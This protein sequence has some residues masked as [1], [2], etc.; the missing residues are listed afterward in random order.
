[1]HHLSTHHGLGSIRWRSL[2][3][4]ACLPWPLNRN[5]HVPDCVDHRPT[6]QQWYTL[7][8]LYRWSEHRRIPS[9]TT[10]FLTLP[11][12]ELDK[13]EE[14]WAEGRD[15]WAKKIHHLYTHHG[16][17]SIRWRSLGSHVC[18]PWPVNRN[19]HVPECNDH[20]V[21]RPARSIHYGSSTGGPRLGGV[22]PRLVVGEDHRAWRERTDQWRVQ[23]TG[24]E[25]N[26]TIV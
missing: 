14:G 11:R 13:R 15:E 3:S 22:R 23:N 25:Q 20:S 6:D 2:G 5:V 21:D 1:M 24:I 12:I 26:R 7:W 9:C 4:H 16:L 8:K 10:M 18:L 19:V 17:G